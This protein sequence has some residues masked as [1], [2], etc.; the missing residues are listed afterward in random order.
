MSRASYKRWKERHPNAR[1]EVYK[2]DRIKILA[3][4]KEHATRLK[5]EV[6][7]HYSGGV[8]HCNCP[9]C[10]EKTND[11]DMLSIEHIGGGG[12]KH[13]NDIGMGKDRAGYRFYVW[14][15]KNDFPAGYEILC[16]TCNNTRGIRGYCH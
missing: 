2:R 10:P 3:Q 6:F 11:V 9:L 5:T 14:L 16:H 7:A 8:P 1:K 12:N 15:K 4:M 13:R